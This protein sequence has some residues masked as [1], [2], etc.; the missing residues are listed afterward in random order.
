MIAW[1]QGFIPLLRLESWLRLMIPVLVTTG[2]FFVELLPW[3]GQTLI[4]PPSLV[5]I[6]IFYWSARLPRLCP[7]LFV[8]GIGL[9]ADLLETTPFGA[10]ASI[11]LTISLLARHKAKRMGQ[12][13]FIALWSLFAIAA[14]GQALF[15]WLCEIALAHTILPITLLL[16][17]AFLTIGVFPIIAKFLLLP[18]EKL[19]L[20]VSHGD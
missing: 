15:M 6:S 4:G 17:R 12:L 16:L 5:L 19:A 11:A 18:S 14:L 1:K 2:L 8:L 7:P 9:C 3:S 20:E 10:Q 13:S